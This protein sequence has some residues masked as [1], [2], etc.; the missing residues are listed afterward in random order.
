MK[1]QIFPVLL[2]VF[3]AVEAAA[4]LIF[5]FNDPGGLQDAV[6]VNEAVQSVQKD[7]DTIE[8]HKNRTDLDY[9]L[10]DMQ[11]NLLFKTKAGLSESIN[12]AVTHM[13]TILDIKKD[14]APVGKIIIYNSSR[15]TFQ[16][17][18]RAVCTV[19]LTATLLQCAV[20]IYW[21]IWLNHTIINPFKKLKG[22][23][24]RI[25][26]GNLDIPL[27]MDKGNLFGAFTESFDIMRAELKRA[28]LAEE[29]ANASKKELVAKLSHDIKTPVA[30]IKAASE[31]GAAFTDNEKIRENYTQIIAK[32]DQINTLVTNL[33]TATLEELDELTV[34]PEDTMGSELEYLLENADYLHRAKIPEIPDCLLYMDKL[35][36]QQVFDNIFSNSYKYA[37][38]K[39]DISIWNGD[40]FCCVCIEDYGGGVNKEELPLLKEKFKRGSNTDHTEGA[41]LGLYISDY[42][43]QKMHGGLTIENGKNGLKVTVMIAFGGTI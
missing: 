38:T 31:V 22:F 20:C 11:E 9:V 6:C 19:L 5:T 37:D 28:R 30:S 3:F 12:S 10:L 29:R 25:A 43:M 32:T 40:S 17:W 39:I 4:I 1:K 8:T 24:E 7:W 15:E 35:R 23:A 41:G 34:T 18:K 42:F 27:T 2:L 14:G 21:R 26:G 13:D 16:M 36:L 33:F